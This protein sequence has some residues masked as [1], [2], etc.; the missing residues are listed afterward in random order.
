MQSQQDTLGEKQWYR[1]IFERIGSR[2]LQYEYT[3]GTKQEVKFLRRL[4]GSKK[5]IRILD[6]GCGPGRHSL[7]LKKSGYSVVGLDLS[8]PFLQLAHQKGQRRCWVNGDAR[9]MPFSKV[10]DWAIC[11]CEGAFGIMEND[12]E[13]QKV[14][15]GISGVLKSGGRL[16][17]NVLNA[18]F[19]FRYPKIDD[20]IDVRSL[21]GYWTEYY[22]ADN[23]TQHTAFCTNRYY[24]V[25]EMEL[26]LEKVG[27]HLLEVWGGRA[28]QFGRKE[29]DLDDFEIFL[30]AEKK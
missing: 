17:L 10:F 7:A 11:L 27:M 8:K 23:G 3:K 12:R 4:L 6:V 28:G 16:F 2:Y 29:L 9:N 26:R 19:V 18:S 24:T 25:P 30:L 5:N 13:N 21:T 20:R 1:D 22:T 14:L 15:S